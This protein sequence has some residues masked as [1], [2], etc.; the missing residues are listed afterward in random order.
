MAITVE[1][2]MMKSNT[3]FIFVKVY[4]E[5]R[6]FRWYLHNFKVTPRN[7]LYDRAGG[8]KF[9]LTLPMFL[10][11]PVLMAV[12]ILKPILM[13]MPMTSMSTMILILIS[14][15]SYCLWQSSCWLA[16]EILQSFFITMFIPDAHA[17]VRLVTIIVARMICREKWFTLKESV[18]K[19]V[20]TKNRRGKKMKLI[21]WENNY[22]ETKNA[23]MSLWRNNI[24][25][26]IEIRLVH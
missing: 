15:L 13:P 14:D 9:K 25:L 17:C 8:V 23:Q 10:M 2:S 18:I 7:I 24:I 22:H 1:F 16:I 5:F 20:K 26:L 4:I 21:E 19:R 3:A 11:R 12:F 6:I